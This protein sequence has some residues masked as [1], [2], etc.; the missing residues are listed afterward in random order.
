MSVRGNVSLGGLEA[1]SALPVGLGVA[2]NPDAVVRFPSGSGIGAFISLE[3]DSCFGSPD[4]G[5]EGNYFSGDL[6]S[7]VHDAASAAKHIRNGIIYLF[8]ITMLR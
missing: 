5:F 1:V 7:I 8:F 3:M 2:A 6:G 4:S